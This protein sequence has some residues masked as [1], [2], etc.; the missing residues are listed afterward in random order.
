MRIFFALDLPEAQR[1]AL[2]LRQA[3]LPLPRRVN[4]EDFHLT[5]AFLGELPDAQIE[6]AHEAAQRVRAA[7][8][9]L[10]VADLGLFG[11][12]KPRLAWAGVLP[13]PELDDLAARLCAALRHAGI[14]LEA[15]RFN[16]HITLGRF[17][18]LPPPEKMRLERAVAETSF[19]LD[20]FPVK[21]FAMFR[22]H[23]GVETGRYEVLMRYP[24][25]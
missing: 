16:P 1:D 17:W 25:G 4:P 21:D 6:A 2:A 14:E 12:E 10:T 23:L 22:S 7:A 18:R 13:C 19:R 8:F 11:G 15:R 3:M 24:L 9:T 5:L 20:P